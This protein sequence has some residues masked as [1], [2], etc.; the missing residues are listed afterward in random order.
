MPLFNWEATTV[1]EV[2]GP[3]FGIYW[4]V[5]IPVTAA[6]LALWFVWTWFVMRQQEQE[7]KAAREEV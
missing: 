4:A 7:N 6:V 3:H 1:S 5:A 2:A